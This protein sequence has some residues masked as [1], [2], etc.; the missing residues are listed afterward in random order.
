MPLTRCRNRTRSSTIV[1]RFIL[2][3]GWSTETRVYGGAGE[4]IP[5]WLTVGTRL[6]LLPL[7]D[8]ILNLCRRRHL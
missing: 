6:Q 3:L 4:R 1:R 8:R 5:S 7:A 2:F